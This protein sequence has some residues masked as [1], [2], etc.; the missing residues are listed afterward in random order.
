MTATPTVSMSTRRGITLLEVLMAMFVLA[1]GILS[2]FGLFTAGRELEARAAIKSDAIAY[3]GTLRNTIANEWVAN[4]K[5]WLY[6]NSTGDFTRVAAMGPGTAISLPV[7]IDP[8]GLSADTPPEERGSFL[9][10]MASE[11]YRQSWKW[12]QMT[13]LASGATRYQ[14]FARVTLPLISGN[15]TP[16]T[17]EGAVASISD[18]DSIEYTLPQNDTDPPLN[19]FELGRRKRGADLIPALFVAAT[20]P[21]L[22]NT[23]LGFN[24]EVK[25]TLLIFHKP[26][27]DMETPKPPTADD[28]PAGYVELQ[29]PNVRQP[30]GLVTAAVTVTRTPLDGAVVR[31]SLRPGNWLLIAEPS[32][33]SGG[34]QY[35]TRWVR[36]K[37]ATPDGQNWLLV[38][39]EAKETAANSY[40][41]AF[42]K[43]VHVVDDFAPIRLP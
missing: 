42:E 36:T 27:A 24:Q 34:R 13:P 26:A 20:G 31:R 2:I 11:T 35:L 16:P 22:Q 7:L 15:T 43:L 25:P 10:T 4:W 1:V 6:V 32:D 14:P 23:S 39:D 9:Q 12:S 30:L 40:V 17:R 33:N 29:V 8:F 21:S 5:D 19:A 41:Y 38:L 28:W 18:Q 37:S 3:A